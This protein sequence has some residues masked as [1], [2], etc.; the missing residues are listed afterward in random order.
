MA[1]AA[2]NLKTSKVEVILCVYNYLLRI[3]PLH[4]KIT[5]KDYNGAI[6]KWQRNVSP[7]HN[8]SLTKMYPIPG[9]ASILYKIRAC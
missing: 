9:L 5:F 7:S 8:A 3:S 4:A 1:H 6:S 2:S